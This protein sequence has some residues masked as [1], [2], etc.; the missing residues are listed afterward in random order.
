MEFAL[1]IA[2]VKSTYCGFIEEIVGTQRTSVKRGYRASGGFRFGFKFIYL[3][4]YL[5][6]CIPG[7]SRNRVSHSASTSHAYANASN[8]H[9]RSDLHSNGNAQCSCTDCFASFILYYTIFIT[10]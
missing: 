2:P 9:I 5:F 4:L 7:F 8:E 10:G 3:N 1:Y 6:N